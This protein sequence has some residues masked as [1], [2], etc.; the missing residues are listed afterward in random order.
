MTQP[1]AEARIH[2][3]DV[4]LL[5]ISI[6]SIA[7]FMLDSFSQLHPEV[8]G[9][10]E[11]SDALLCGF[12]FLDFLVRLKTSPNK[13]AYISSA[14]I[15]DFVSS[16]PSVG[17]F[18]L[19]RLVRITRILR[20]LRG[21]RSIRAIALVLRKHPGAGALSVTAF[22]SFAT[23]LFGSIAVLQFE[24]TT[25]ANIQTA[26]DALWWAFATITTVGYGDLYPVTLEG[27]VTAAVL[28]AVGVSIFGALSGLCASWLLHHEEEKEDSRSEL[29]LQE[30]ADIKRSLADLQALTLSTKEDVI[31]KKRMLP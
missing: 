3:Y 17:V 24:R 15:L 18:R 23:L 21:V 8:H 1:S 28:M 9:I 30:L 14:G 4:F 26:G 25:D 11:I 10:L 16:I 6:L 27:R 7:V 22:V 31:E 13:L 20:L 19:G 29:L 2:P 5:S 12:F